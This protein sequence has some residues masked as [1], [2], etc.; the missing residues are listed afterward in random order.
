MK[1]YLI[2]LLVFS[3]CSGNAESDLE[4]F[5]EVSLEAKKVMTEAQ[6]ESKRNINNHKNLKKIIQ[7]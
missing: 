4:T 7:Q 3:M 1:K 2:I 5:E 6:E